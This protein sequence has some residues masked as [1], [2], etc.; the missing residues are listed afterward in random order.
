MKPR[1]GSIAFCSAGR[2]G[3]I[4]SEK[5]EPFRFFN[6][7]EVITWKGIQLTD[8]LGGKNKDY[9]QKAGDF[10]CSQNPVVVGHV[11]EFFFNKDGN[12]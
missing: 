12:E 6:G 9:P 5:P 11:S 4:T 10:W 2:L 8:G 1:K 3:L 7:D